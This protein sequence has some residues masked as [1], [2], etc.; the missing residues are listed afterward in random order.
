MDLLNN[1]ADFAENTFG[2]VFLYYLGQMPRI[3]V[4]ITE[5]AL[6]LA[7]L[8]ALGKMSRHNE[9]TAMHSSG[10]SVLRVLLPLFVCGLWCSV[11]VLALNF[12]LAPEGQRVRDETRRNAAGSESRDTAVFN[13]FYRNREGLRTWCLHKVPYDLNPDNPIREVA[14]WQQNEARD[15]VES[16]FARRALWMPGTGAWRL[17]D[18]V[19]LEHIDRATGQPRK[20]ARHTPVP[21]I[22]V[23]DW[24]E[25]PGA[26]L[27]DKLDEDYLGVPGLLSALKSRETLPDKAI[28]RYRTALQ[29][30]FAL[31]FRCFLIVL[32]AAPLGIAASRRNVLGGV[33]AAIGIFIAVFFLSTI[34]FT[35]GKGNYLPPVAAAWSINTLCAA[36]GIFLLWFRSRNRP[37]PSLRLPW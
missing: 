31:P 25:S 13:V 37:L 22:E 30:R 15:L 10:R 6:L 16:W 23:T 4:V 17:Y 33:S 24:P 34:L 14:V 32:V 2:E 21:Y 36:A 26:M 27:S 35:S 5:A 19:R 20:T 9:L 18:A 11:A 28:A 8:F 1:A 12:Q 29:W 7:T 3:L